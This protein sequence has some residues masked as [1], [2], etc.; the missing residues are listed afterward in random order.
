MIQNVF[1]NLVI[2]LCS[3]KHLNDG[4]VF[5]KACS[6]SFHKTLING[7]EWYGLL[8]NFCDLFISYL[9]SHSDG[10]HSLQT[11]KIGEQ[12]MQC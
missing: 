1:Y 7:L 9:D 4:F 6:F 8:V 3:Q 10:T 2:M 12:E 5:L 11:A